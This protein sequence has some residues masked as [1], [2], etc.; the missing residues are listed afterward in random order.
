MQ[1]SK[2]DLTSLM[3]TKSTFKLTQFGD[4]EF[5]LKPCTGGLLVSLSTDVGDIEK[6]LSM[7]SAENVSKIAMGLM[8]Y[9]SAVKFKAQE[10]KIINPLTGE[11]TVKKMG[12]YELLMNSI[13]G[14]NEQYNIYGAIL[15]SMGYGKK[16]SDDMVKKLKDG[17]NKVIN[18]HAE[19]EVKK[20]TTRK[21]KTKKR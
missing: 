20:K 21:K 17:I 3:P 18:N 8:E 9:E 1:K 11:D 10:V 6:L 12:G 15:Q 13:Q 4:F 5:A 16:E 7:P 2:I 19:K 14:I